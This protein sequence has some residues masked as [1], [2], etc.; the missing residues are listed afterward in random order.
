MARHQAYD[1]ADG[2]ALDRMARH[3]RRLLRRARLEAAAG[4]DSAARR[5][6]ELRQE[7]ERIEARLEERL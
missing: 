1:Q 3:Y 7:L 4:D 2:A 5:A 6:R